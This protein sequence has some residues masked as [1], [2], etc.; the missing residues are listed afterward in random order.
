MQMPPFAVSCKQPPCL[1]PPY[2]HRYGALS[3][4]I[5][6]NSEP[7]VPMQPFTKDLPINA[8]PRPE[9]LR[10]ILEYTSWSEIECS[11]KTGSP[12]IEIHISDALRKETTRHSRLW[13]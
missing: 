13:Y 6:T 11:Q 5:G 9:D 7:Q 8:Y 2:V 10:I 12:A 4:V 1:R 3:A